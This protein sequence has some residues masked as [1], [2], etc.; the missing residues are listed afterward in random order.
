M[1]WVSIKVTGFKELD[2]TLKT[3]D[4]QVQK[5]IVRDALKIAAEPTL[6]AARANAPRDK[7]LLVA[8]LVLKSGFAAK[9]GTMTVRVEAKGGDYKGET[10]YASF[11]EYGHWTGAR[12]Q[13]ADAVAKGITRQLTK[14]SRAARSLGAG[15]GLAAKGTT[16]RARQEAF[17]RAEG[18][19]RAQAVAASHT[20]KWVEPDAFMR[21]AFDANKLAAV[22]IFKVHVGKGIEAALKSA[23]KE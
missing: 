16:F 20:R 8:S 21:P 6:H 1:G 5:T 13:T 17:F 15:K 9:K 7:G 11:V 14:D 12:A 2:A 23:G 22:E 4:L 19:R 18:Q 3:L 10:F